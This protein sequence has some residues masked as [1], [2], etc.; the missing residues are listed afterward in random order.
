MKRVALASLVGSAIEFYDFFLYGTAAA[1]V[2]PTV[3]FANL[4]PTMATI[5]SLAT[6]AAAFFSRPLGA[7]VFGHFGDRLGRKATLVA[8][9]LIMGLSTVAVGLLPGVATIGVAA[10]LILLTLRLLQGLALGGEWA[11]SA[12]LV[13]E[14]APGDKR[15]QYGMFTPLGAGV[16][17]VVANLVMLAVNFA[18]GETSPAFMSWGW[19]VPF[20]F[21]AVLVLVALYVRL[22]ITETPVF[23]LHKLNQQADTTAPSAPIAALL[24]AQ[25]RQVVLAAGCVTGLF[26]LS[27]MAGTYLMNYARTQLG[28]SRDLILFVGVFGGLSMIALV[29]PAAVWS[30]RFGRRRVML[31]GFVV[32]VPWAFA[33]MPLMDTGD[34]V[35]FA[36]AIT[37]TYGIVGVVNGPLASFIPETF[38]T[39][40]RFTGAGLTFNAGG[41]VGGAAPPIVAGALA[42]TVGGWAIGLMMAILILTSLGCTVLLPETRGS[43]LMDGQALMTP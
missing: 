1:L 21:S 16:G 24:R 12:L 3:F 22:N 43:A 38:A 31:C 9:L 26:T 39:R 17:L 8:T 41:I 18:I 23:A 15:G 28:Y 40:Y 25:P 20:L 13:A 32:G 5:A 34:S 7:A 42:T 30:D 11:G 6:F 19:R 37:V 29:V 35:L 10:P 33:M 14:H 27:F 4:G 36:V 2:F